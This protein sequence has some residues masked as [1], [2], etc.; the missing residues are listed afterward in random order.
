MVLLN[1]LGLIEI[2]YRILSDVNWFVLGM[3]AMLWNWRSTILKSLRYTYDKWL[4]SQYAMWPW[5]WLC[6]ICDADADEAGDG[7]FAPDMSIKRD[8]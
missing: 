1:S 3:S 7:S 4:I 5:P 8:T 6:L 2:E